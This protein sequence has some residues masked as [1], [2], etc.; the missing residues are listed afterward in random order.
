MQT[1]VSALGSILGESQH[2]EAYEQ[3][4]RFELGPI[5]PSGEP[6]VTPPQPPFFTEHLINHDNLTEGQYVHL[7]ARV[8]PANDE[9]LRIE[10]YKN[11]KTL[12]FGKNVVQFFLIIIVIIIRIIFYLEYFAYKLL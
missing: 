12:V 2:P 1:I 8:E 3:T 7:E 5:G 6:E 4:Q 10:W 9:K 11:G